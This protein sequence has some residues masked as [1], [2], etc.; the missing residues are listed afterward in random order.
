MAANGPAWW[1][2]MYL[3]LVLDSKATLLQ[4]DTW[5]HHCPCIA[6]NANDSLQESRCN[7]SKGTQSRTLSTK[8]V[9]QRQVCV[10]HVPARETFSG[11]ADL[12]RLHYASFTAAPKCSG[13]VGYS[14]TAL[15]AAVTASLPAVD[16]EPQPTPR[17]VS[18]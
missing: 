14:S 5:P 16:L 8:T 9:V 1:L 3:D 17:A 15:L 10:A 12:V 11:A 18:R 6:S 4:C 7:R 13:P 2:V